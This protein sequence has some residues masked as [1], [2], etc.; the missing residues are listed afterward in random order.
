MSSMTDFLTTA[1]QVGDYY[2]IPCLVVVVWFTLFS[3]SIGFGRSKAITYSSFATG[4]L[5]LFLNLGGYVDY[6]LIVADLILFS[7]GILMLVFTKR[8]SG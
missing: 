4:V 3:V 5:L 1:D 2:L 7:A 6:W 8:E